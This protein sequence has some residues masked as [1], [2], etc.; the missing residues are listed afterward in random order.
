MTARRARA[1]LPPLALAGGIFWGS[2]R[3][4]EGL[5]EAGITTF[6]WA[7]H[8]VVYAVL[9]VLVYRALRLEGYAPRRSWVAAFALAAAYGVTDE[10]HQMF[11]PGRF[12]GV[13]DAAFDALGALAG[14]AV[15]RSLEWRARR[16]AGLAGSLSEG[17]GERP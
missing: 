2:S 15:V 8:T 7:V 11:V 17:P 5:E 9:A 3:A 16:A 4:W 6:D 14:V 10:I 12:P 1:W 13:G